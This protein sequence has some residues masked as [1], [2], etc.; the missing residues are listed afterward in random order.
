M[1]LVAHRPRTVAGAISC[2]TA[3]I[4]EVIPATLKWDES[5][6]PHLMGGKIVS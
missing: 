2:S 5:S 4:S 6:K 3:L 1:P